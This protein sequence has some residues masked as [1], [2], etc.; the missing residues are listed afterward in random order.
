MAREIKRKTTKPKGKAKPAKTRAK[1]STAN[2]TR[3][4]S[5]KRRTAVKTAGEIGT[6]SPPIIGRDVI[7]E[8]LVHSAR[9][10]DGEELSD[11]ALFQIATAAKL[12]P[13]KVLEAHAR[14]RDE[15]DE[16]NF[17]TVFQVVELWS[18][19]G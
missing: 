2:A 6:N 18:P 10:P 12:D 3:K 19:F 15:A 8:I 13:T 1:R 4:T 17:A 9:S 16:A 14:L 7:E 5:A 11:E